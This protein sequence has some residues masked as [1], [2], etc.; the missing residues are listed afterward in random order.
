LNTPIP[1]K[2]I[3]E[4]FSQNLKA[5]ELL[6]KGKLHGQLLTILLSA[7]DSYGFLDSPVNQS[8]AS[9]KSFKHWVKKYIIVNPGIE[10]T[11]L[12]LWASRCSILHTHTMESDLSRNNKAREIAFY[13]GDKFNPKVSDLEAFIKKTKQDKCV[14][15]NIEETYLSFVIS[16]ESFARDFA[17]KCECNEVYLLRLNKILHQH[18]W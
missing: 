5:A 18:T 14:V 8:S 6:Y 7:I 13:S 16:S 15:A 1:C 4:Y 9:G 12:D 2:I 11:E 3:D 10:Y 17:K